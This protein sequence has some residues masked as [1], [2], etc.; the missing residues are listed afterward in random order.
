MSKKTDQII[1]PINADFDDVVGAT[2]GVMGAT[3]KPSKNNN[4]PLSTVV[5]GA[6]PIQGVLF[7]VEKQISQRI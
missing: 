2:I 5:L 3:N 7:H 6:T 1:E 4:L